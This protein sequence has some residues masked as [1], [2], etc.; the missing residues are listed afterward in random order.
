MRSLRPLIEQEKR[1]LEVALKRTKD[2]AEWRRLF[3]ILNEECG[4]LKSAL[5]PHYGNKVMKKLAVTTL[6][7]GYFPTFRRCLSPETK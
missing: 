1:D 3:V 6:P 4:K 5:G 2:S 7:P